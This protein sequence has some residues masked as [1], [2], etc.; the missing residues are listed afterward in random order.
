M[1]S[2]LVLLL[3]LPG[4][5]NMQLLD[6]LGWVIWSMCLMAGA[7]HVPP[8]PHDVE[9]KSY[10]RCLII[11]A[12]HLLVSTGK[13]KWHSQTQSQ[14]WRRLHNGIDRG[15]MIFW[16]PLIYQSATE[17]K[18]NHSKPCT[19]RY[20]SVAFDWI[21]VIDTARI[22]S[23]LWFFFILYRQ[24]HLSLHLSTLSAF[25]LVIKQKQGHQDFASWWSV[26]G[27]NF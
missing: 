2:G 4:V 23:V 18:R 21:A 1:L 17:T 24:S 13:S 15:S 3:V 10:C 6:K 16:K 8:L 27:W 19:L 12:L 25:L 7:G 9:G 26:S 20:L 14:C 11:L 5:T 22:C